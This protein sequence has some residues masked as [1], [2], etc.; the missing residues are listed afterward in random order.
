MAFDL[1]TTA[2]S[3]IAIVTGSVFVPPGWNVMIDANG[4]TMAIV[5]YTPVFRVIFGSAEDPRICGLK[6][7]M[8]VLADYAQSRMYASALAD[9]EPTVR[10]N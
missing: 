7:N 2:E 9:W 8:K 5:L 4:R 6:I 3:E 1:P 10:M